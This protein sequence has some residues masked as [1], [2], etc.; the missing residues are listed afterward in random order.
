MVLIINKS[1]YLGVFTLHYQNCSCTK[2]VN[3]VQQNVATASESDAAL[4]NATLKRC[5]A[6]KSIGFSR[7]PCSLGRRK[8]EYHNIPA[9]YRL[10]FLFPR[11]TTDPQDLRWGYGST[12]LH[13]QLWRREKGNCRTA[14][15]L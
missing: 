14:F 9:R 13:P 4:T 2:A 6:N 1:F 15:V 8:M 10:C 3:G 5:S 12:F 7:A 11:N